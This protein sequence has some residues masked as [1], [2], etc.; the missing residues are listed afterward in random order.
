MSRPTPRQLE[1]T[2]RRV[3][4][5]AAFVLVSPARRELE[6]TAPAVEV[7]L[8]YRGPA[9]GR[10]RLA[11][12]EAFGAEVAAN[13]MGLA[14]D[15]PEALAQA[16]AALGELLNIVAGALLAETFGTG[17]V[18]DLGLPEPTSGPP[19]RDGATTVFLLG[20]DIHPI[21]LSALEAP[22]VTG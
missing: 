17:Q 9:C 20:D 8:A 22:G 14:P 4:E 13:L 12:T 18:F 2:A 16:T 5:E 10:L 3:F 15:D 11:A 21:V 7:E 6:W 19:G 1:A